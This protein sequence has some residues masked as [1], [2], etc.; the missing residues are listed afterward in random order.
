MIFHVVE[1]M[2]TSFIRFVINHA[3]DRQTDRQTAFSWLDRLA[4]MQRGETT[5]MKDG[6]KRRI[7][8]FKAA[9]NDRF[10]WLYC[11]ITTVVVA[12]DWALSDKTLH[13]KSNEA[14]IF[15]A[16]LCLW[17]LIVGWR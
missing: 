6:Y 10:V 17:C 4:F 12:F 14:V 8:T 7:G 15:Y 13:Y 11:S 1:N 2:G 3:F 5:F 9:K 16:M